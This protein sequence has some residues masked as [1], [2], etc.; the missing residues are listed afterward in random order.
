MEFLEDV[1]RNATHRVECEYKIR[2]EFAQFF[3][4]PIDHVVLEGNVGLGKSTT[5]RGWARGVQNAMVYEEDV[6]MM[7]SWKG[8]RPLRMFYERKLSPVEF[9]YFLYLM[10]SIPKRLFMSVLAIWDRI[11]GVT[12][13]PWSTLSRKT[14]ETESTRLI[15]QAQID[16]QIDHMRESRQFQD[17][18]VVVHYT[19]S[20][21]F[22]LLVSNIRQRGRPYESNITPEYLKDVEHKVM[23]PCV[24]RLYPHLMEKCGAARMMILHHKE[25]K[26]TVYVNNDL[27]CSRWSCF[28]GEPLRTTLTNRFVVQ[29]FAPLT[30]DSRTRQSEN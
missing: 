18:S 23:I 27:R 1:R 5:S 21:N 13:I 26:L 16:V 25:G 7:D 24:F 11:P 30:Y 4:T 20:T 12:S 8:F 22:E 29:L 14:T 28:D 2:E 6:D 19:E 9:Q 3:V 10:S 15:Q 17:S